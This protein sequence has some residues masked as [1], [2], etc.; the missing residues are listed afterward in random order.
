M[1]GEGF[2]EEEA[3]RCLLERG[4]WSCLNG[5]GSPTGRRP[6]CCSGRHL[7]CCT[8]ATSPRP[9]SLPTRFPTPRSSGGRSNYGRSW[10]SRA[11][12]PG[13][14]AG[15]RPGSSTLLQPGPSPGPRT[16][17]SGLSTT[18]GPQTVSDPAVTCRWGQDCHV[19][20]CVLCT[21]QEYSAKGS[22]LCF[23]DLPA[24]S[25]VLKGRLFPTRTFLFLSCEAPA[26]SFG[27]LRFLNPSRHSFVRVIKAP[28]GLESV[29]PLPELQGHLFEMGRDWGEPFGASSMLGLSQQLPSLYPQTPWTGR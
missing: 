26:F 7:T 25:R 1:W 20:L 16:P 21:A 8:C 17:W 28:W 13:R 19:Q 2:S 27:L 9:A 23:G 22:A 29:L 12:C 24:E 15:P 14:C 18:S 10:P 3:E 11:S 6:G 5:G 4:C